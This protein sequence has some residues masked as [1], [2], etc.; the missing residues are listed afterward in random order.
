MEVLLVIGPFLV[1][2][3]IVIFIAFS[4]GPG[5]AREAYLTRGGRAVHASSSAAL[6]RARRGRAGGGDRRA[7]RVGGRRRARCAPSRPTQ[8]D[9]E[10]KELFIARPARAATTSTRSRPTGVTGPDLDELGGARPPA[11]AERDQERRHRP[12]P[13]AGG[14]ARGRG[15]R[16]GRRAT[17]PRSPA[18]SARRVAS[19]VTETPLLAALF[20]SDACAVLLAW[21]RRSKPKPRP[22]AGRGGTS[23]PSGQGRIEQ[24]REVPNSGPRAARSATLSARARQLTPQARRERADAFSRCPRPAGG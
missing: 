10:G 8:A 13:H 1:L 21:P 9:E 19:I 4:G 5:A 15:R 14:P 6:P 22:A 18:S 2:G 11:R 12:G 7:R 23:W 17:W 24:T 16:G 20:P 3:I